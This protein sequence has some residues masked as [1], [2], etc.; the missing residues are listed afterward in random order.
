[1]EKR[2]RVGETGEKE[3]RD[4]GRKH[5]YKSRGKEKEQKETRSDKH[6]PRRGN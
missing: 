3:R 4:K 2:K 1:M 5:E 6:K